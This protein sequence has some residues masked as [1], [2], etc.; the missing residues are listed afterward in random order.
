L[1][2]VLASA[3]FIKEYCIN[4]DDIGDFRDKHILFRRKAVIRKRTEVKVV[5]PSISSVKK[6]HGRI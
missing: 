5:K 6:G 2:T 3:W 4:R 1:L